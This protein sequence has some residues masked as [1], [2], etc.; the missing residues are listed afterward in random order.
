M[1]ETLS[2]DEMKDEFLEKKLRRNIMD[3][4]GSDYS[5]VNS[6]SDKTELDIY[7]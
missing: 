5:N 3:D 7:D 4:L 6:N 1:N 2:A